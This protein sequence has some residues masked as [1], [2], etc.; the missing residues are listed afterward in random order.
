M[1]TN[2]S[3]LEPAQ[4]A[5]LSSAHK[6]VS[7]S[8]SVRQG[9]ESTQLRGKRATGLR[10][11]NMADDGYTDHLTIQRVTHRIHRP[12]DQLTIGEVDACVVGQ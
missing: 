2:A 3:W 5:K 6:S 7:V 8:V 1:I 11:E 12:Y 10:S 4:P 9:K